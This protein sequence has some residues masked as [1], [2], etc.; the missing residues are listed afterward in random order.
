M[1]S[2]IGSQKYSYSYSGNE[3]NKETVFYDID[4]AFASDVTRSENNVK[5]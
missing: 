3:F 2:S 4:F 5:N 1:F